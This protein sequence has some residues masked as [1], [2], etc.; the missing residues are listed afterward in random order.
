[1][2]IKSAMVLGILSHRCGTVYDSSNLREEKVLWVT[3]HRSRKVW[4]Q[5]RGGLI[6][7]YTVLTGSRER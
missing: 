6:M 1:M 4:G 7:N 2:Q 5:E 3:V